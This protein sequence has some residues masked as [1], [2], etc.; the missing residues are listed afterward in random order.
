MKLLLHDRDQTVRLGNRDIKYSLNE[1]V[2]CH[3]VTGTAA[4]PVSA[5]NEQH[6]CRACHD[7]AAVKIDCFQCHNSKPDAK[8]QALLG[9]P[10][11][12]LDELSAYVEEV[13]Q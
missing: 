7:F 1:C 6:F 8:I 4:L 11:S 10:M 3:V 12:D 9:L 13:T 5:K 2:A